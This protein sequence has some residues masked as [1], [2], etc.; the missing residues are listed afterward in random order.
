MEKDQHAF[1][2]ALPALGNLIDDHFTACGADRV[3]FVVIAIMHGESFDSASV[4][5]NRPD[6]R[7]LIAMLLAGMATVCDVPGIVD[8]DD[9]PMGHA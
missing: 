2:K 6:R 3:S 1:R 8:N 5:G 4:I 7:H 9:E